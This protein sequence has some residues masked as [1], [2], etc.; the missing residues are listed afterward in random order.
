MESQRNDNK[1]NLSLNLVQDLKDLNSSLSEISQEGKELQDINEIFM[2]LFHSFYENHSYKNEIQLISEIIKNLKIIFINSSENKQQ[3][4]LQLLEQTMILCLFHFDINLIKIGFILLKFLID[5][6][7]FPYVNELISYFTK[8]M[9][10]L[11]FKKKINKS[12][13]TVAN[14]II[15]NVSLSLYIIMSN[16]DISDEYKKNFVDFIKKNYEDANLVY[17]LFL[18]CKNKIDYSKILKAE[19]IKYILGKYKSILSKNNEELSNSLKKNNKDI[20]FIK[21]KIIKIGFI[22]KILDSLISKEEYKPYDLD[23]LIKNFIPIIQNILFSITSITEFKNFDFNLPVETLDNIFS[24]CS[25]IGAFTNENL[26]KSITM[27]NKLFDNFSSDYLS[28]IITLLTELTSSNILNENNSKKIQLLISQI[29]ERVFLY[30]QK[31]NNGKNIFSINE[32]LKIHNIN[33]ILLNIG[34][35]YNFDKNKFPNCYRFFNEDNS[36]CFIEEENSFIDKNFDY[37]IKVYLKSISNGNSIDVK[38]EIS[39][40]KFLNCISKF[41]EFKKSIKE[42]CDVTSSINIEQNIEKSKKEM[43]DKQSIPIE[44][45]ESFFLKNTL[46]MLHEVFAEKNS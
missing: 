2:K 44:S 1:E 16:S 41:E 5:H 46:E 37:F 38:N 9:Q 29:L 14:I 19:D 7:D 25:D 33:N 35:D 34:N 18:P 40:R 30:N 31:T 3:E 27:I 23:K 8:I 10:I 36:S 42:S 12:S 39:K 6:L 32:L 43:E 21:E 13:A 26:L 4:V 17:L 28:L 45:F 22:C 20:F 11:Y 15:F 24:F